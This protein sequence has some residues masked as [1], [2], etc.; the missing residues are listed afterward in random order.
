MR[1][2]G[3][4]VVITGAA[5]GIGRATALRFART[6]AHVVLAGRR[7][8]ALE[9]VAARCRSR[10]VRALAVPTDVTDAAAVDRLAQRTVEQFGRIDVWVNCASVG[11]FAS[12]ADSPLEDVRRLLDVNVMGYVHGAR[13]AL[14]HMRRQGAG[15]LVNVSSVIG[16]VP[17]P[18]GFAYAMAKAAVR[19]LSVSLRSELRLAGVR[20]I[21]VVTVIPAAFDTPFFQQAANYTGHEVQPIP[22]VYGPRQA[23]RTIVR[24]VRRPRREVPAGLMARATVLQHRLAPGLTERVMASHVDRTLLSRG[25]HVAPNPGNLYAPSPDPRDAELTGG[26]GGARR[27]V[28]RRLVAG[29]VLAGGLVVRRRL[30]S[31]MR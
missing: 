15:V 19:A 24:A 4:V 6:G 7:T 23:A 9:E 20:G 17:Q 27:T 8:E 13:A 29:A 28:Q 22:P 31:P 2:K 30:N 26:W 14:A 16:V 11:L 3:A 21:D 25:E 12:V 10:G 18:Y 1:V 5:G